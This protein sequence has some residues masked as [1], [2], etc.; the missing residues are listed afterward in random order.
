MHRCGLL[1]TVCIAESSAAQ[2]KIV[3]KYKDAGYRKISLS[4]SVAVAQLHSEEQQ[5]KHRAG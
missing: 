4:A 5:V 2:I 3:Q 1:L